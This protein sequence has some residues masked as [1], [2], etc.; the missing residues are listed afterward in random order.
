MTFSDDQK[1]DATLKTYEGLANLV[2]P[3]RYGNRAVRVFVQMNAGASS[4]D[5]SKT[6]AALAGL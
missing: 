3:H 4:E 6:K 1:F 5:A 2:G